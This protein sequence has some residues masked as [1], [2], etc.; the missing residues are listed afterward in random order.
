M[1]SHLALAN[2]QAPRRLEIITRSGERIT[3]R[4]DLLKGAPGR[5]LTWDETVE[6]FWTCWHY[7]DPPLPERNGR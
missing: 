2:A 4:I 1:D 6:K 3:R 5:A 7:A